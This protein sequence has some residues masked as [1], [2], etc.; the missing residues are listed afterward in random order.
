MKNLL[1]RLD[2]WKTK[3]F[4]LQRSSFLFSNMREKKEVCWKLSPGWP[5]AKKILFYFRLYFDTMCQS[6][7]AAPLMERKLVFI[8]SSRCE[9]KT[10]LLLRH[11]WAFASSHIVV[12]IYLRGRV[13]TCWSVRGSRKNLVWHFFFSNFFCS[14]KIVFYF[15]PLRVVGSLAE[16]LYWLVMEGTCSML[17]TFSLNLKNVAWK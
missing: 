16:W 4:L 5:S 15:S 9:V 6:P 14:K 8:Q 12:I 13:T 11:S 17:Q 7:P 1:S 2:I 10:G 3:R